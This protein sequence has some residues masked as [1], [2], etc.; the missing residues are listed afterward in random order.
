MTGRLHHDI[1]KALLI[2]T[3]TFASVVAM[4][5]DAGMVAA[6]S[7]TA[8]TVWPPITIASPGVIGPVCQLAAFATAVTADG[9]A[10][11]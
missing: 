8:P 10:Q 7:G 3:V 1:G 2:V 6:V 4:L 11:K 9:G 5:P